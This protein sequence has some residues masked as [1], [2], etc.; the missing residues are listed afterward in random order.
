MLE[1][2]SFFICITSDSRNEEPP[3]DSIKSLLPVKSFV[4]RFAIIDY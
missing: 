3:I 2:G 1:K 4:E